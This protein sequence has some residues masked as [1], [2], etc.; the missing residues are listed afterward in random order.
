LQI[1][2][3]LV[4][5]VLAATLPV[6]KQ[7]RITVREAITSYGLG[8]GTFGKGLIDRLLEKIHFLPRP[9][10]ISLRN[11][12]RRKARLLLTLSTMVLAGAIFIGVFNLRAAMSTSIEETFGYIL[13][14]VNIG[15]GRAY[16]LQKV[17]ELALSVPGVVKAESWGGALGSLLM[18]G[19]E[20][21]TQ[22]QFL[23]PP[24]D[25]T[26]I[27]AS[28]TSG[29]WLRPE[30]QN[31]I[32]IGNHLIAVRPELKVGDE[33]EIDIDG[34]K[35]NWKIVG[36]YRFIGNA[37]P[38][39]VY[40][41]NE[42][43]SKVTHTQ[44]M[45]GSLRVVT[46]QHDPAFQKQVGKELERAYRE[47]GIEVSQVLLGSDLIR[48]NSSTTDVLVLFLMIMALLI[49]LVG[50]LGMTSTMGIN[51]FERTREIGVMRAIGASS[52]AILRL[53]LVE[54]MLIGVIS[55]IFGAILAYPIARV[56]GYAVGVSMFKSPLKFVFALDG[57]LVWL[58]LILVISALACIIP[59]RNATRLTV[60][61]VLAYE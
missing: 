39:L 31:A 22:V 48:A 3:G 49:A 58:A 20:T 45:T 13:S 11:T 15:F 35:N 52:G 47:D 61:E 26:L 55:W 17:Q 51:V 46:N 44:N 41:N 16:R 32:V 60:R 7:T 18:P 40:T 25:S 30:D 10:L 37:I 19:E 1:F 34:V 12:F 24:S 28:I 5:P 29:R 53:V 36:I 6:F 42:Y 9:M 8:R 56:L 43:L 50:G 2:V 33:V 38:P 21:G 57:L 27:K 4:I 23:A 59:A 14:D 54:G